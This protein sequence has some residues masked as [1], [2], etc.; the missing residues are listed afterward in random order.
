MIYISQIPCFVINLKK[1]PEK[2]EKSSKVLNKIDIY[3]NRFDAVYVDKDNFNI[4]KHLVH[5]Y[6]SYTIKNGRYTDSEISSYGA[7][8]CYLSHMTLWQ[9]LINSNDN[10]FLICEDDLVSNKYTNKDQINKYI[11]A[12]NSWDVLYLGF[13]D[14]FN[15]NKKNYINENIHKIDNILLGTSCYL[16]TKKG[17]QR[18]LNY[19]IPI[20]QQV[21]SYISFNS[22]NGN[23]NAYVP[24]N[25]FFEQ[26]S[27]TTTTQNDIMTNI[28]VYINRFDSKTLILILIII[29]IIIIYL[30][31]TNKNCKNK[32]KNCR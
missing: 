8:G 23:I 15:Y 2:F 19:S 30:Q 27:T 5:P 16:I 20:I 28:K 25:K 18:L 14:G 9:K 17:A 32:L 21:D 11:N 29:F 7:I 24:K 6:V 26:F 10:I 31:I 12:L 13:H 22:I 3:P 4:Y 1:F